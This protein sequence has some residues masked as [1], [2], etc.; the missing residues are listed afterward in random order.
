MVLNLLNAS[1]STSFEEAWHAFEMSSNEVD[2]LTLISAYEGNTNE[3]QRSRILSFV[4][5]AT[6]HYFEPVVAGVLEQN[7]SELAASLN[8]I[9]DNMK[10][11]SEFGLEVEKREQ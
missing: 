1:D 5:Y 9:I 7:D 6:N 11:G 10:A 8:A 3:D 4:C 2:I